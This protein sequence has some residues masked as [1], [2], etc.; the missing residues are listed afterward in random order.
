MA[1]ALAQ[2][3]GIAKL[4]DFLEHPEIAEAIHRAAPVTV[5]HDVGALGFDAPL[6]IG[7]GTVGLSV[8]S[9]SLSDFRLSKS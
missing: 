7:L 8:R 5:P 3:A 6:W 2:I 4:C 9:S 1:H